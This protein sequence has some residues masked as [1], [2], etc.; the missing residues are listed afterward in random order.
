MPVV[1]PVPLEEVLLPPDDEPLPVVE[2]VPVEETPPVD[3]FPPEVDPLDVEL[4]DDVEPAAVPLVRAISDA[5]GLEQAVA[6]RTIP[7]ARA[8]FLSGDPSPF[9]SPGRGEG[10]FC[11]VRIANRH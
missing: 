10:N 1:V 9:L 3:V 4:P 8:P 5:D 7:A 11:I 6:R 2:A